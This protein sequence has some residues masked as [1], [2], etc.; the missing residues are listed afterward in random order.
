MDKYDLMRLTM[1]FQLL[2]TRYKQ[3]ETSIC[4]Q[5]RKAV[6]E[7]NDNN[8]YFKFEYQCS[9]TAQI[10]QLNIAELKDVRGEMWM[11]KPEKS[12][13][14]TFDRLFEE[15]RSLREEYMQEMSSI[16]KQMNNNNDE[17]KIG[18][19]SILISDATI[20][21]LYMIANNINLK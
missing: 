13:Y 20:E 2:Y 14:E 7:L 3:E 10:S 16:V 18:G 15:Y 4:E 11:K 6:L 5:M 21:Q 17:Y 19:I 1:D 12:R 8:D 9:K